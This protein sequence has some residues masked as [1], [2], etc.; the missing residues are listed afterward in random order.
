MKE[1]E[2]KTEKIVQTA[3]QTGKLIHPIEQLTN[4]PLVN[5]PQKKK[6]NIDILQNIM[7]SGANEFKLKTG[8]TPSYSEMRQ[9]YG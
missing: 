9:M 7:Q 5:T 4:N 6:E 1:I 2:R 8:Q 3:I